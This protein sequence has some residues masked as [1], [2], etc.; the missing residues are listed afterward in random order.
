M[1]WRALL[2]LSFVAALGGSAGSEAVVD[3]WPQWG[4]PG[5]DFQAPGVGVVS[6]G[7][8]GPRKLWQRELGEG[9]SGVAVVEGKLFTLLRQGENEVV[10]A[11]DARTGETL[12]RVA[13]PAPF[14]P[15]Y[16]MSH[17]PGPHAT[18]LGVGGRVF[19]VGAT[20]KLLALD[21]ATGRKLWGHD[22]VAGLGGTVRV[23][24]Y[25]SSPI[26]FG[27]LVILPVGETGHAVVAFRQS[28]GAIA[29]SRHDFKNSPASPLL[30][31]VGGKPQL[32]AFLY[33]EV[34]G[35]DPANGD[36]LWSHPHPTDYGLN[37][38]TPVW[39]E[40]GLLFLSSAYGGGSRGLRLAAEGGKTRVEEVW[41]STRMRLHFGN[42]VR[43]GG[44]V[45]GSSGDFGPAPFIALDLATGRILW[46]DRGFARASS[47]ALADGRLLILDEDGVLGLVTPTAEGLTI[48]A[49]AQL[50][51]N[52][53]WTPPALV[54]TVLYLRDRKVLMAVELGVPREVP[55]K[56]SPAGPK[57]RDA[58][59]LRRA[60]GSRTMK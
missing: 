31:A 52:P 2:A 44:T 12:W 50:L 42:A 41:F 15:E 27:E 19:A 53:A 58:G 54:G 11:L 1:S 55:Q 18:P 38:S 24:G 56:A 49:Q 21:A 45:Y 36:L 59:R 33:G 30:I 10:V 43:L 17:G 34:V 37:V 39:G 16:D 3:D 7:A 26:A 40:D 51:S 22:L 48:H 47:L 6:W 13:E 4:G 29:W 35:L 28:D 25:A 14:P 5:R 57:S 8:E 23:N 20:G 32:V 9:F 60:A 46:R